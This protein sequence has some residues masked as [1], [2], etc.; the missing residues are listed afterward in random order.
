MNYSTETLNKS[1]TWYDYE[2]YATKHHQNK[3]NDITYHWKN[4]P[5]QILFDSGFINNFNKLRLTRLL[6]KSKNISEY[7]LDAFSIDKN[8]NIHGLQFKHYPN[9]TLTANKLGTFFS[10]IC[11]RLY[12]N[13][14]NSKGY[15]YYDGKLQIDL[16]DDLK[17]S[18][19]IEY[20]LLPYKTNNEI[21]INE[22]DYD[23]YYFQKKALV[24][25]NTNWNG[26]KLLNMPCGTGKTIIIGE[27]LKVQNY[28][29]IFILSPLKTLVKQ[30]KRRINNFLPNKYKSML[31]DSD[32][33]GCTNIDNISQFINDNEFIFISITYDSFENLF[34]DEF[35]KYNNS[36][37]IIDEAHDIGS[38]QKINNSIYKYNK[39]L[40]VTA[41]PLNL[42]DK[43]VKCDIIYKL[44][45][46][47]AING[48]YICDF[49]I[50]LPIINLETEQYII[51]IPN[52]IKEHFNSEI[53]MKCMFLIEGML[54]NGSSKCIVYLSTKK[55]C[56]KFNTV[57]NY[58]CE[59]YHGIKAYTNY[60]TCDTKSKKRSHIINDF[61]NSNDYR[62][63]ILS[64]VRILN[65]GIDIKSCD[66]VFITCIGTNEIISVQR[67]CRANRKDPKNL[68]KIAHCYMWGNDLNKIINNLYYLRTLNDIKFYDFT[69]KI[70]YFSGDY[71]NINIELTEK[72][73]DNMNEMITIKSGT[74][75]EIWDYRL[76]KCSEYI[77]NNNCRPSNNNKDD[78]IKQLGQWIGTQ[79]INYKKNIKIMS[80]NDIR[81]KWEDF[82]EKYKEHFRSNDEIWEI[83]LLKCSEYIDNNQC[84]PSQHN[85]DDNIKQL[86]IWIS[87]QLNQYKKNKYI[88]SNNDMRKKWE[89]FVKKYNYIFKNK[90]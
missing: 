23:L 46:T 59:K 12:S 37:L 14:S 18:N 49:Q 52:E 6:N 81:K 41:T 31:V 19:F 38:F 61:E 79:L 30:M 72:Y 39:T 57:F 36:I 17:N 88:M 63:S 76:L 3:T 64:N 5:D 87:A 8:N 58:V 10:V 20:E 74:Y 25:L 32:I 89:D 55:E 4:I 24:N 67:A 83:Q 51:T 22:T 34:I 9:S 53:K 21:I 62:L 78:N 90:S 40:L 54:K 48:N 33:D 77:D 84:R 2:L 44:P 29:I 66:S 73:K 69:K 85:K 60:I 56:K 45:F 68:N 35:N 50:N 1:Y 42:F 16:E 86:G 47:E 80:N 75:N 71:N 11:N 43:E 82:V 13:N 70:N 65:Q 7:G 28:N 15:L 27:Y 26:V